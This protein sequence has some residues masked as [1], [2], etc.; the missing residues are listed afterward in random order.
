MAK[1]NEHLN[2]ELK[3]DDTY[4]VKI[5]IAYFMWQLGK[6]ITREHLTEIAIASNG[7]NYFLFTTVLDQMIESGT[8]LKQD[9]DGE[10]HLV[11]SEMGK[12]GANGFK[13]LVPKSFRDRIL[14]SGLKFFAQ[15]KNDNNVKVVVEKTNR[16]YSVNCRCTEGEF[17]LMDLKL[18]APDEEQ[19]EMLSQK[20]SMNPIDF[21][22][23]IIDFAT[24]NE[25]YDPEPKE[26]N[27]Q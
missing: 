16:G 17:V 4:E 27:D 6:P 26:V 3:L 12:K 14:S 8:V 10:E 13:R 5:L 7:V 25:D 21:Y 20:I 11:L 18:F 15:L 22:A 19:A 9:I 24:G 1:Y 23:K 2:P